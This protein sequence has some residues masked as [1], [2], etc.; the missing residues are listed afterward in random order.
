MSGIVGTKQSKSQIV[1]TTLEVG[2]NI[3]CGRANRPNAISYHVGMGAENG[4]QAS[5][6]VGG[7]GMVIHSFADGG[8]S[9][10]Q[11]YF[12]THHTGA[13]HAVRLSID[14][15]GT[16]SGSGSANISDERLKENITTIPDALAKINALTGRTFTWKTEA[17]MQSGTKY[18][19]IAQ[20]LETVVPDLVLP[21]SIRGIDANGNIVDIGGDDPVEVCKST[22]MSGCIP[23]LIEAVKELSVK[24]NALEAR[25]L[26]LENA[27]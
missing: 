27:S 8:N 16:F 26:T 21:I 17:R 2:G 7:A 3:L 6:G 20:E 24:N 13:S 4:E 15:E 12:H 11:L 23:I 25:V 1:G 10:Q 14:K 5:S 9:S 19:L 18:G 22:D